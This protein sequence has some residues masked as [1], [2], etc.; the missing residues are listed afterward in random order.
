M[1]F[2]TI[3][4][5]DN[6]GSNSDRDR[7]TAEQPLGRRELQVSFRPQPL[8]QLHIRADSEREPRLLIRGH[9]TLDQHHDQQV[10]PEE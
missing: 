10:H 5:N 7:H 4:P 9:Y 2:I 6:K 3:T 8:F 1:P